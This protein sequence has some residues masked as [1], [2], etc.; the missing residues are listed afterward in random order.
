[1]IEQTKKYW[2]TFLQVSASSSF[3]F[4]FLILFFLLRNEYSNLN[5][6]TAKYQLF[7]GNKL[8]FHFFS[9]LLAR[10]ELSWLLESSKRYDLCDLSYQT[11]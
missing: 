8:S 3:S 4:S 9:Y 5:S 11:P 10:A 2:L 6:S 1:M 7:G